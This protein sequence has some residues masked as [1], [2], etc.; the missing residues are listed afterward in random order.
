MNTLALS[1]GA[2]GLLA[3]EDRNE[4]QARMEPFRGLTPPEP[5]ES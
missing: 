2:N 1:Y 3:A 4:F 5:L